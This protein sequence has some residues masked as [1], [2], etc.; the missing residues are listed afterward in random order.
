MIGGCCMQRLKSLL[1]RSDYTVQLIARRE[2]RAP[3]YVRRITQADVFM[4]EERI[5]RGSCCLQG[6]K[7]LLERL[8]KAAPLMAA[9]RR[10]SIASQGLHRSSSVKRAS[11]IGALRR[12]STVQLQDAAAVS[13]SDTSGEGQAENA[14]PSIA[15]KASLLKPLA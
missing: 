15:S 2:S 12:A 14:R 3:I 10:E 6:L 11:A 13:K 9:R 5:L 7:S 4:Y 1:E 8:D